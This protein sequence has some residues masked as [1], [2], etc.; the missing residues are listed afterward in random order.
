MELKKV[1]VDVMLLDWKGETAKNP[2]RIVL[3]LAD[4]EDLEFFKDLTIAKGK[5]TGQILSAEFEVSSDDPQH[6]MPESMEPVKK[7]T[8]TVN[9]LHVEAR[10]WMERNK[11]KL[12]PSQFAAMTCKEPKYL[13]YVNREA[14]MPVVADTALWMKRLC[15]VESRAE[16]DYDPDALK[17]FEIHLNHYRIFINA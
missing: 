11:T 14:P 1:K 15:D 8:T 17:R 13:E 9:V 7:K 4:N 16:F 5:I 3:A 6:G 2:P 10:D 12:R